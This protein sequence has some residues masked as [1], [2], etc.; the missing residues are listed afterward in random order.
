[1]IQGRE[2]LERASI[3]STLEFVQQKPEFHWNQVRSHLNYALV[4][5]KGKWR[6]FSPDGDLLNPELN[7]LNEAKRL[8]EADYVNSLLYELVG[9][10]SD[11]GLITREQ[12]DLLTDT[13][14]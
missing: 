12:R 11:T 1:M 14:P 10:W 4:P 8:A 6:V 5:S 9:L 3:L 7:D 13:L 2:L